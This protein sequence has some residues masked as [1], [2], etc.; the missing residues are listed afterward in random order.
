M[1]EIVDVKGDG[2]NEYNELKKDEIG[3]DM[4]IDGYDV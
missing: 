4:G 3:V 2:V 1:G